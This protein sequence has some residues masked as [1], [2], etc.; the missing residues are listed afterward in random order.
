M[1][2]GLQVFEITNGV[3]DHF[4]NLVS[5]KNEAAARAMIKEI[6]SSDDNELGS[7]VHHGAGARGEA[8]LDRVMKQS[9]PE[10]YEMND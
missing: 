3:D 5:A 6:Q 8:N 7:F 10:F 9:L 1:A 2:L 4:I